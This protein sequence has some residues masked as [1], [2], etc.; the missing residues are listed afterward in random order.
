MRGSFGYQTVLGVTS[1]Q[2]GPQVYEQPVMGLPAAGQHVW[3]GLRSGGIRSLV[4]R[5]F[6]NEMAGRLLCYESDAGGD[7]V[8]RRTDAYAGLCEV[9]DHD[10]RW[11]IYQPGVD[12]R[13]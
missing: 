7:F 12:A 3:G 13:F 6:M 9:G 4:I 5:H 8:F 1:P 11:G 2:W 10:G